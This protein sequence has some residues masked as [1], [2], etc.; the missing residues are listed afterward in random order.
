MA[1]Q[2]NTSGSRRYSSLTLSVQFG[3]MGRLQTGFQL[4][5]EQGRE[6][7]SLNFSAYLMEQEKVVSRGATLLS[8]KKL[9]GSKIVSN[10]IVYINNNI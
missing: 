2:R 7:S 3:L 9:I 5:L 4:I 10:K 1:F 6:I 8:G